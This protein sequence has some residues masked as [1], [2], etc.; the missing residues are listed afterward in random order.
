MIDPLTWTKPRKYRA[1]DGPPNVQN[2]KVCSFLQT[3]SRPSDRKRHSEPLLQEIGVTPLIVIMRPRMSDCSGD[4]PV[5]WA[6]E[7]LGCVCVTIGKVGH[8]VHLTRASNVSLCHARCFLVRCD[9]NTSSFQQLLLQFSSSKST[10]F[11]FLPFNKK[12]Y[13]ETWRNFPLLTGNSWCMILVKRK[14]V[15]RD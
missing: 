4:Q 11:I 6:T 7:S 13:V 10:C 1:I 5:I 9:V 12:S 3:I 14:N 15:Y 2:T 8:I